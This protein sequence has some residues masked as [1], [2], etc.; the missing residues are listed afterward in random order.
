MYRLP[1]W[2]LAPLAALLVAA[3]SIG[4]RGPSVDL[5]PAA[6]PPDYP[7]AVAKNA[8]RFACTFR[9]S[10]LPPFFA[11]YNLPFE[12]RL[13]RERDGRWC[14]V[15]YEQS[16]PGFR[17]HPDNRRVTEL[18]MDMEKFSFLGLRSVRIGDSLD[19][20]KQ[21][22]PLLPRRMTVHFGL[23]FK[24]EAKYFDAARQFHFPKVDHNLLLRNNNSDETN[25]WVQDYMKSGVAN[26]REQVLVTRMAYEGRQA[27]GD[28]Y[29]PLLDSLKEDR[30]QRSRLSWEGGDIQ[31]AAHPKDPK[32]TV[33]F[34]G[35]SAATYWA[36][37]LTP[38]EYQW[39]L[40]VEFGADEAVDLSALV[41]HVD[42][43]VCSLPEDNILLLSEPMRENFE[44][45]R[46]ALDIL[47][48]H[49]DVQ[50]PEE[51]KELNR[52]MA[53]KETAFGANRKEIRRV[54]EKAR[55]NEENWP[56]A[57]D[58][59]FAAKLEGYVAANCPK[60]P[61][62]CV[63]P[64]GFSRLLGENREMLEGWLMAGTR[65]REKEGLARAVLSVI[66]TNLPGHPVPTQPVI[67]ARAAELE[68]MGYRVI[69]VPRIGG[70]SGKDGWPGISYTNSALIDNVLFLPQFGF[71]AAETAVFANVRRQLP[72]KY[73][74]A[75]IFA[76]HMLV[77]NGG[78]HC[79]LAFIR[80]GADPREAPGVSDGN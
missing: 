49:F 31:F 45:A 75:P 65:L 38:A 7:D 29:R 35:D 52:L 23:P 62:E 9:Q 64:A 4:A 60:D 57:V 55:K 8:I 34:Y 59:A 27:N 10:D 22:L 19:I 16:I 28:V 36:Y 72:E 26:G 74:V 32:R 11:T 21:M 70:R 15:F 39:I 54:I 51:L 56:I 41:P 33:M 53:S 69:R 24:V 17:V 78:V 1:V 80:S 76:R 71:G 40:K 79:V 61:L 18:F 68:R 13:V 77:R 20:A 44:I 48:Q 14:H 42:Y 3:P 2:V 46:A 50:Q 5:I 58:S 47:M 66:E 73:R 37:D 6:M 30:F 43:L 25:P 67:D 63:K 12:K